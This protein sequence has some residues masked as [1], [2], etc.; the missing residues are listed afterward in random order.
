M[1]QG[2]ADTDLADYPDDA[3]DYV[4]LSQTLQATQHPRNPGYRRKAVA[5]ICTGPYLSM[6]TS[7]PDASANPG[8]A[9]FGNK[10]APS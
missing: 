10:K 3:F 4:I 9:E 5:R 1:I 2:N 7:S 8:D 6:Q